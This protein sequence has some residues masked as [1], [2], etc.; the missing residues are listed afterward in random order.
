MEGSKGRALTDLQQAKVVNLIMA[1]VQ[2]QIAEIQN[3]EGG[4]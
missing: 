3:V 1:W 2:K 4:E